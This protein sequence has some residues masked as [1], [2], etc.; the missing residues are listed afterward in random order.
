MVAVLLL[1]LVPHLL[2]TYCRPATA[3]ASAFDLEMSEL[4]ASVAVFALVWAIPDLV[5]D[6][7]AGVALRGTLAL[8]GD[9]AELLEEEEDGMNEC[10]HERIG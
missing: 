7:P 10:M 9:V 6:R 8:A 5:V 2:Q 1:L 4:A 3:A